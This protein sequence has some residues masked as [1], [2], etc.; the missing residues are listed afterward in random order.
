MELI[1]GIAL[2]VLLFGRTSAPSKQESE[3]VTVSALTLGVV[4]VAVG[5]V[6][7]IANPEML[8]LMTGWLLMAILVYALAATWYG[9]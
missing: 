8:L 6:A 7:A 2:G 5:V 9:R 4:I 3:V 1:F